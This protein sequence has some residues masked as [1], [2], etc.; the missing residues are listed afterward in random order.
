VNG[1]PSAI[2]LILLGFLWEEDLSPYELA[3]SLAERQVS[4]FLKISVPVVYKRCKTLSAEGLVDARL[5]KVG[6]QPEKTIYRLN[7]AGRARFYEL[8]RHYSSNLAPL[9]L[10]S[11]TFVWN[12][13]KLEKPVGL[14]MLSAMRAEFVVLHEWMVEHEAANA[15]STSFSTRAIMKQYRMLFSTLLQWSEE[16]IDDYQQLGDP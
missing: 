6:A 12:L 14:E 13:E 2:D 16:V 1:R 10:E 4:R 15:S 3:T 5:S 9:Y 8:M 7:S 11:N